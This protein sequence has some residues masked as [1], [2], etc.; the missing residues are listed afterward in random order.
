MEEPAEGDTQQVGSWPACTAC[1][2]MRACTAPRPQ[3]CCPLPAQVTSLL[4]SRLQVSGPTE[5][6]AAAPASAWRAWPQPGNRLEPKQGTCLQ[7]RREARSSGKQGLQ[8]ERSPCCHRAGT[9]HAGDHSASCR[10][11]EGQEQPQ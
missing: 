4:C 7:C 5:R 11:G 6:E 9:G 1:V 3:H 8:A 2:H 10:A